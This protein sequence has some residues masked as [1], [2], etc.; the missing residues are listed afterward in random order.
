[1]SHWSLCKHK[2]QAALLLLLLLVRQ[3][4]M[5]PKCGSLFAFAV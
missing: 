1:M 3:A 4:C 2:R 5:D